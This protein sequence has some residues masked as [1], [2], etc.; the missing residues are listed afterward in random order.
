MA[1]PSGGMNSGS[2]LSWAPK[3]AVGSAGKGDLVGAEVILGAGG[4]VGDEQGGVHRRRR[5]R[6][7]DGGGGG[8]GAEERSGGGGSGGKAKGRVKMTDQEKTKVGAVRALVYCWCCSKG[9]LR[10]V[11]IYSWVLYS[12]TKP[13]CI[14]DTRVD[15]RVLPDCIPPACILLLH[16]L[17]FRLFPSITLWISSFS[18]VM[19]G[20]WRAELYRPKD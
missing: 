2:K 15:T 8:D 7:R 4:G 10:R 19:T 17:V 14:V 5:H 11:Y 6:S 13:G 18:S 3:N 12:S 20:P 16:L 1:S 9:V